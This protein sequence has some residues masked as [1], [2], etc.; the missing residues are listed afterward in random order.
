[1]RAAEGAEN[2]PVVSKRGEGFRPGWEFF[3]CKEK[4]APPSKSADVFKKPLIYMQIM[5]ES[6]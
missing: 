2:W 6:P 5:C 1:M 3:L 4:W